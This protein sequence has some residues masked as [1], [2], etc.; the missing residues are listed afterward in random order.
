MQFGGHLISVDMNFQSPKRGDNK[1]Y[2]QIVVK[3]S[4]VP[5][6]G[7]EK[8]GVHHLGRIYKTL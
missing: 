3:A 7:E 2:F 5:K 8:S 4:H 6:S 1:V